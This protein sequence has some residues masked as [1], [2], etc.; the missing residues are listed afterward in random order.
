MDFVIELIST[1]L[2]QVWGTFLHNWPF[3]VVSVILAAVLK[4]V[5]DPDKIS[6]FLQ[7]YSKAG[8]VGATVVAVT[9]PLCSCGTMAI[10]LGMMANTMPWAPIVAFM[11]SSPLTSPEELIYSAGLFGWPFA[12]AFFASSIVLGLAGGLLATVMESRGWL[13]NQNRFAAAAP[14][15]SGVCRCDSTSAPAAPERRPVVKQETTCACSSSPFVPLEI[16]PAAVA[17]GC[18]CAPVAV[19]PAMGERDTLNIED[20]TLRVSETLRVWNRIADQRWKQVGQEMWKVTKQLLP[21]FFIFAFVG[22]FLN[23]LIPDAWVTAIFGKGNIYS[24]PLA[25][26]LGL[27]LYINSEASLP[28]VRALIDGGMSQ[29]AALAF[30]IT[31]AGT[32]IGALTGALTIARWRVIGLVV[33]TLWAGSILIGFL[34]NVLLTLQLF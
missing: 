14:A 12:V 18:G 8:V 31:G 7:R 22:Y 5:L 4:V 24:V 32:S 27:P 25:A 3:L 26:T 17:A 34:Y 9:T 20:Q 10:I 13:K 30:L 19:A 2:A 28:L 33:G 15:A 29:G 1:S 23:G 21:M 6:A 11:V 16:A